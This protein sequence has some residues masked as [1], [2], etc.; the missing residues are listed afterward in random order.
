MTRDEILRAYLAEKDVTKGFAVL[1]N[2]VVELLKSGKVTEGVD[3]LNIGHIILVKSGVTADE[4]PYVKAFAKVGLYCWIC[5]RFMA[6]ADG[7][8][9]V[10]QCVTCRK[11]FCPSHAEKSFFSGAKCPLCGSKTPIGSR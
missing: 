3:L 1:I 8:I 2:G 11:T 10:A 5:D 6:T 9:L 7:K 4:N